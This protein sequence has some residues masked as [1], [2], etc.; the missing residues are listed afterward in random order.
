MTN[1]QRRDYAAE[2]AAAERDIFFPAVALL[3][4]AAVF[5]D[6]DEQ[7]ASIKSVRGFKLCDAALNG[8]IMHAAAMTYIKVR[9]TLR[10]WL[11]KFSSARQDAAS[12]PAEHAAFAS[13]FDYWLDLDWHVSE[14]ERIDALTKADGEDHKL[15]D[16][17]SSTA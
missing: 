6:R 8:T 11:T 7:A 5:E 1:N 10:S 13:M 14:R 17:I 4:S 16:H 2:L 9:D 3:A 15:A 12:D